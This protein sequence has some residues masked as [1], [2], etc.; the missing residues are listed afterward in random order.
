MKSDEFHRLFQLLEKEK[1]DFKKINA[2]Q[3]A[4]AIQGMQLALLKL[5]V[6]QRLEKEN[7]YKC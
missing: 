5:E 3:A 1:N 2:T 6:E 7:I 4:L